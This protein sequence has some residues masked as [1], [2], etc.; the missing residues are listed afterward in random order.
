MAVLPLRG[1]E[2][3]V[4]SVHMHLKRRGL[5]NYRQSERFILR[6]VFFYAQEFKLAILP[7]TCVGVVLNRT[8]KQIKEI[9]DKLMKW[10]QEIGVYILLRIVQYPSKRNTRQIN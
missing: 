5:Y 8:G 6:K 10:F 7:T 9:K 4:I 1:Q 3:Q 2:V